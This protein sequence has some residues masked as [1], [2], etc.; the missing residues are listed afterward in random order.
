MNNILKYLGTQKREVRLFKS[1]VILSCLIVFLSNSASAA[2]WL[3]D[4]TI[5]L[6]FENNDNYRLAT[7]SQFEDDVDTTRL[8]GELALKGKSERFNFRGLIRLDAINY[9]GDDSNLDDRNNQTASINSS[10]RI[11]ERNKIF[12]KSSYIRDTQLRSS[13]IETSPENI[14]DEGSLEPTQDV[15]V[16]L[17]QNNVR[18][19]RTNINPRWSYQLNE[20]TTLGLSYRYRDLSFSS[21]GNTNVVESDTQTIGAGI[22][23]QVTEKDKIFL[24]ISESYFRPDSIGP[25]QDVDT[26]EARLGWTHDFSETLQMDLTIGARDSDFDNAQ[27]SSDSGFVGNIGAT[28]RAGLT[29]Y[30]INLETRETPSSSGNQLEVDEFNLDK[31]RDITEK[32]S[33]TFDGRW[34]DTETTDNSNSNSNR[35]YFSLTP[36]LSWRFLP[37]WVASTHYTYEEEDLDNGGSGDSNSVYIGISW[38]PPKQF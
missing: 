12:I 1:F 29:T 38:S 23:R 5:T 18:R 33:F 32:V 10:Y 11:S 4:P 34:F 15:D 16:N 7:S 21:T 37:S 22:T 13:V 2:V 8:S 9:S 26:L 19:I 24:G 31:E 35:E 36:E 20:K 17:F 14:G 30:R 25:D 27:K 3:F 28:K 6:S